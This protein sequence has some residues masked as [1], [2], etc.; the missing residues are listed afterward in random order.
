[1]KT[2]ILLA[3]MCLTDAALAAD[4]GASGL[5]ATPE[6]AAS[7]PVKLPRGRCPTMPVPVMPALPDGD[8]QFTARFVLKADG[9]IEDLR[10]EGRGPPK[11]ARAITE[12]IGGYRCLPGATD[13]NIASEFRV[14]VS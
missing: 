10:L 14:K 9:R 6:A 13:L 8:F 5:P 1:M 11:L 2:L 3:A 7:A 4:L 12:A